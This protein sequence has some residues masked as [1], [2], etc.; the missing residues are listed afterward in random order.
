MLSR[1][2]DSR[3]N[4]PCD[5]RGPISTSVC[6]RFGRTGTCKWGAGCQFVHDTNGR[7]NWYELVQLV[8]SQQRLLAQYGLAD[9]IFQA[10]RALH[11]QQ[12][13]FQAKRPKT[14]PIEAHLVG[15]AQLPVHPVNS[16]SAQLQQNGSDMF[17]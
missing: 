16:N 1:C 14:A 10:Q 4:R 2:R 15:T 12:Q 5:S 11:T 13:S 3:D 6:R 7:N 17:T 8:Q 9:H